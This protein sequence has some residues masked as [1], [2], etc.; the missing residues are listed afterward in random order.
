M[1][2][3][4][5]IR[6]KLLAVVC[7]PVL[8]AV[9]FAGTRIDSQMRQVERLSA[10]AEQAR[11][12]PAVV[13]YGTTVAIDSGLSMLRLPPVPDDLRLGTHRQVEQLAA[14]PDLDPE[15]A[16]MLTHLLDQGQQLGLAIRRGEWSTQGKGERTDAFL[17]SV[18]QVIRAMLDRID[19]TSALTAGSELLEIWDAQRLLLHQVT[20][21]GM[22]LDDPRTG[23]AAA[24]MPIG[25]ELATLSVLSTSVSEVIDIE[26]L[27][28]EAQ[29]RQSLAAA[30]DARLDTVEQ[31][32]ASSIGSS[33]HY[34]RAMAT[35]TGAIADVLDSATATARAAAVRDAGM[36]LLILAVALLVAFV[37][38]QSVVGPARR[39]R[40]QALRTAHHELPAAIARVKDGADP[41]AMAAA[42]PDITG[43]DE[44]GGLLQAVEVVNH[45]ALRLAADQARLRNQISG[46][47]ETLA[48]RSTNLIHQQLSLIEALEHEERDPQRLGHLFTLD[49]LA[50]RMK[51]ASESL[52]V[53]AGTETRARIK[54]CALDDVLRAAVSQVEDYQRV[55]IGTVPPG[56][57]IGT[58]VQDVIHLIAELVDNALQAST[59]DTVVTFTFSVA[60]DGGILLEIADAGI[61]IPAHLLSDINA[62][63]TVSEATEIHTPSQM[64]LFVVARL[65]ARH[66]IQVKLRSTF[67]S[68]LGTG[69]TASVYLPAPLLSG[70][71]RSVP[72]HAVRHPRPLSVSDTGR[73][74]ARLEPL[75]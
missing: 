60:V 49:H 7:V 25:L 52:L 9:G 17:T 47:L 2:G 31:L 69:I 32:R 36:V 30:F 33:E 21:F 61:G 27:R 65:A 42:G 43:T 67:D 5:S 59:S 66:R 74:A 28:A 24:S 44:I 34:R 23:A 6:Y 29:R 4:W 72:P 39:A 62:R 16:G 15:L 37:V 12:L 45:T 57:V 3:N 73:H 19:Y 68:P 64:G 20:A 35:S 18:R 10:L 13:E 38:A 75:R 63:M 22:L 58:A 14:R 11:A 26:W 8:A 55:R 71:D 46:M 40:E 70:L 54:S 48:R 1:I 56:A 50:T 41:A 53:L 51:R